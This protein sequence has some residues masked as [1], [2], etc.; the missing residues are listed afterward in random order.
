MTLHCVLI[1]TVEL[2]D[3]TEIHQQT[4]VERQHLC[5]TYLAHHEPESFVVIII[6]ITDQG[7]DVSMACGNQETAAG[8]QVQGHNAIMVSPDAPASCPQP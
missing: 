1:K 5:C 8:Q 6:T 2:I 3:L 4:A 7:T